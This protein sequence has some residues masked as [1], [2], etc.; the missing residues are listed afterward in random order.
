MNYFKVNSFELY[1]L[2]Y[3]FFILVSIITR[4]H[5][6][7]IKCN[8]KD[9][10]FFYILFLIIFLSIILIYLYNKEK[11]NLFKNKKNMNTIIFFTFI[12][13]LCVSIVIIIKTK[14]YELTK[15]MSYVDLLTEPLKIIF[16][17]L[18]SIM[19]FGTVFKP[20]I[21]LCILLSLSGIVIVLKNQ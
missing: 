21:L 9:V 15:N 7:N 14:A 1:L 12:S 6:F 10:L 5:L 3:L 8:Y 4:K 18:F 17:Y 20:I 13:S 16:L 11:D 19:V 2:L